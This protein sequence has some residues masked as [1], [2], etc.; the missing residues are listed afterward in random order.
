MRQLA[1]KFF[2]WL[3]YD[4]HLLDCPLD[5]GTASRPVAANKL[6]NHPFPRNARYCHLM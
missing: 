1:K 5:V 3:G 4:F 6:K 2:R